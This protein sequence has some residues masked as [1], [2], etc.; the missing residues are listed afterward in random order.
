MASS[1]SVD[2]N[3]QACQLQGRRRRRPRL[4][5][6]TVLGIVAPRN[7]ASEEEQ[8][9]VTMA[10]PLATFIQHTLKNVNEELPK[11]TLIVSDNPRMHGDHFG[12]EQ[13]ITLPVLD[14]Y[15]ALEDFMTNLLQDLRI[16]PSDTMILDDGASSSFPQDETQTYLNESFSCEEIFFDIETEDGELMQHRSIRVD[17]PSS[18]ATFESFSALDTEEAAQPHVVETETAILRHDARLSDFVDTTTSQHEDLEKGDDQEL[19]AEDFTIFA[20]LSTS[21]VSIFQQSFHTIQ[22]PDEELCPGKEISP[23]GVM[24]HALLLPAPPILQKIKDELFDLEQ[25]ER[26]IAFAHV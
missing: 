23:T 24:D 25:S 9:R 10:S 7:S 20:E 15:V 4:E 12:N 8:I 18:S 2:D 3:N 26:D 19:S 6:A 11:T 5:E 1:E 22:G 21:S 13:P 14:D 16:A 17:T